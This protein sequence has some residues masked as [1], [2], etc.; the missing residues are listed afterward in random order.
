MSCPTVSLKTQ[1]VSLFD[2]NVCIWMCKQANLLGC[3]VELFL[4][5]WL[6]IFWSNYDEIA[7]LL[8]GE[9]CLSWGFSFVFCDLPHEANGTISSEANRIFSPHSFI[10]W[11]AFSSVRDFWGRGGLPFLTSCQP[12]KWSF[13]QNSRLDILHRHEKS[14]MRMNFDQYR[15]SC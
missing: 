2:L 10:F 8:C 13:R 9:T 14:P 15:S 1:G 11:D 12:L 4:K 3:N 7:L 6:Q 5:G